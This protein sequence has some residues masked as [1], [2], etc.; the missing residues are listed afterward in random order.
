ML[1]WT[2]GL[3]G[4]VLRAHLWRDR[5][6][7]VEEAA[8]AVGQAFRD[9][10]VAE[11]HVGLRRIRGACPGSKCRLTS[12]SAAVLLSDGTV[13]ASYEAG[14]A[15]WLEHFAEQELAEVMSPAELADRCHE[16]LAVRV[17]RD[18][19]ASDAPT[20]AGLPA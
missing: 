13:A 11:G 6:A 18:W 5:R 12:S 19:T 14:R 1:E 8:R 20:G 2:H 3:L 10:R 15:R 17:P 4:G 7:C 9:S 16:Q